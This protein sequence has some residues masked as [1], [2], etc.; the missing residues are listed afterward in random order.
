MQQQSLKNT[1]QAQFQALI[2]IKTENQQ[3][4]KKQEAFNKLTQKIQKLQKEIIKKQLQFDLA[5][6]IYGEELYPVQLKILQNRKIIIIILWDVYKTNK[7]SKTDQRYLKNIIQ[8]HLQEYFETSDIE[9][10]E[11][12]QNIF[13]AVE[14]IDYDKMMADEKEKEITFLQEMLAKMNVDM[15][16]IDVND[17]VALAEKIA[18]AKKRMEG[19]NERHEERLQQ[20]K[21]KMKTAKQVEYEKMQQAIKEMKQKNISTIYKQLAKLFHPDLEQDAEKKTEKEI[22]MKE[23]TAAYEAKNLHTL[24]T[25]ELKWIHKQNDH[26]ATLT[27]EKLTIYLEILKEQAR[28]LEREKICIFQK[29]QYYALANQFG[30]T[31]QMYPVETVKKQ[32]NKANLVAKEFEVHTTNFESDMALRHVKEMIKQWKI[33]EK[34]NDEDEEIIRLFFG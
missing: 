12:L 19:F 33:D 34:K 24:L 15:Q 29:P 20:K 3:L 2:I 13:S 6:K 30:Y 27:D 31:V 32:V 9:P 5:L 22:L 7:L 14:G 8:Y 17:E 10:D 4:S 18:E 21:K 11:I 25:L 1:G 16:G 26:L 28:D 23:L